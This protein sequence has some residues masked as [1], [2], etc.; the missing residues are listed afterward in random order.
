MSKKFWIPVF[1][2]LL[3]ALAAGVWAYVDAAAQV[4]VP[5]GR[6]RR[7]P[8][9]LGQVTV[10]GEHQFTLQTRAGKELAV[11]FDDQTRFV[12]PQKQPLSSADLQTDGWVAVVIAR[13]SGEPPLARLVVILP[14]EFDPANLAGARGLVTA[15]DVAASA[16]TLENKAGQASTVKVDAETKY[17]GQVQGLADLKVDMLAQ[18]RI[19][20]LDNGDLLANSVRAGFPLVKHAGEVLSVDLAASQF[21]MQTARQDQQLTITVDAETKFRSRDETVQELADLQPGMVVV[22]SAEKQ[23]ETTLLARLVA[24]GDKEDL[25]QF[26]QRFLG[27]VTAIAS[28]SFTIQTRQGEAL[29]FQVTE[30]TRFRSRLGVVDSLEDLKEGMPLVVGANELGDGQ[31]QAILVLVAPKRR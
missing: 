20:K 17:L 9:A 7:L 5:Q 1:V 16:F 30:E 11:R 12:D 27:K 10:V 31:Y 26:D 25:P 29:T 14:A 8:G 2:A 18:A 23:G 22:V 19:E 4:P 13:N 3:V 15:V 28:E 24:A 21:V 6:Q